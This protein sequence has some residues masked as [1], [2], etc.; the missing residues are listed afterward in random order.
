MRL[1][2]ADAAKAALVLSGIDQAKIEKVNKAGKTEYYLTLG[3]Y[4]NL[5]EA[6]KI[7][8]ATPGNWKVSNAIYS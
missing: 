2:K 8:Q 3:V 1:S 6:K 4:P 7:A 5:S